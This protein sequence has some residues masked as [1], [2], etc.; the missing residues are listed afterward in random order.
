MPKES[1]TE[2]ASSSEAT[3]HKTATN[4][5][6]ASGGASANRV[7]A[8]RNAIQS[9]AGRPSD[10]GMSPL[11]N[12]GQSGLGLGGHVIWSLARHLV[13]RANGSLGGI[14][15]GAVA[16]RESVESSASKRMVYWRL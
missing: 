13:K 14:R 2:R 6:K 8:V 16:W 9:M 1:R 3:V 5:A 12:L 15:R 11:T 10:G 7:G 4:R